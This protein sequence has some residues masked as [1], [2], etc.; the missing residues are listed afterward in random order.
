MRQT[1]ILCSLTTLKVSN[2]SW[3]SKIEELKNIKLSRFALFLTG[4][5]PGEREY[6]F[7]KLETLSRVYK[8]EIPFV[9][10]TSDMNDDEFKRLINTFGTECF[11]LHPLRCYPL[12]HNLSED[13]KSRIYIENSTPTGEL[14]DEDIESFAGLCLDLS[15]CEDARFY[16]QVAF[17]SILNVASKFKVGA[18]HL[19]SVLPTAHT[20]S[21]GRPVRSSHIFSGLPTY[22][23]VKK[24][25]ENFWGKFATIELDDSF[26][27]QLVVKTYVERLLNESVIDSSTQT[28]SNNDSAVAA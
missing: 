24:Y 20:I 14:F 26:S 16:N 1:E 27:T 6:L 10:A 15:H 5:R 23:Y 8:F 9:H 17:N 4:I 19:S 22:D 13:V 28:N 25:P 2:S 11:N 12:K 7:E 21:E 18:N 3:Q